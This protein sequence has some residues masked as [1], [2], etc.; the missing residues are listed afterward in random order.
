MVQNGFTDDFEARLEQLPCGCYSRI[1]G[2]RV[3]CE[4]HLATLYPRQTF[5]SEPR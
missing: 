3:L 4:P 1:D 2:E 5:P